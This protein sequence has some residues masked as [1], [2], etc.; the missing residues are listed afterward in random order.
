MQD[1]FS[2]TFVGGCDLSGNQFISSVIRMEAV[3]DKQ[4]AR[5]SLKMAIFA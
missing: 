1:Y 3:T 2:K 5:N 4:V